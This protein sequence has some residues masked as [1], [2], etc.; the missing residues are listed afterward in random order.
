MRYAFFPGCTLEGA[1]AEN[2][3]ATKKVAEV[4][5]IELVEIPGWSCC[6]ASHLQDTDDLLSVTVNARNIALAEKMGLPLLTVCNTCTLM[7]K[8][9]K[10]HLDNDDQTKG[11][12]NQALF[13]TGLQ[14]QG[15]SEIN[16]LL[17]VLIK[18]Y[19]LAKL[20]EKIVKPLTILKI[21]CYY[22]CHII[23]PPDILGFENPTNPSSLELIVETLGGTVADF[24][25]RLD[26][27]GF[28]AF[29]PAE[30]EMLKMSGTHC[31]A[32]KRTGADCIVTPCPLC[33]MQLD[34][35][36][37]DREKYICTD[38]TI[39]V[40]HLSQLVGLALGI[41]PTELGMK[42]NIISTRKIITKT[43]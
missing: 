26:C 35:Y 18:D 41:N 31:L 33:H 22:G 21:A 3:T 1:A 39:P 17:W 36:K 32:A 20:K 13:E 24:P 8:K 7:L 19:S 25:N 12:V 29:F 9:A 6:G 28:H 37:A 34:M 40:L 16:H 23:R 42:H 14:Y 15:S 4:L 30:K 10:Q 2:L 38:T 11:T 43:S 5:G 27:C